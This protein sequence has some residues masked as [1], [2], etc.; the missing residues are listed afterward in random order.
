MPLNGKHKGRSKGLNARQ[1]K[2]CQLF[3]TF[4][5]ASQAFKD[6]GYSCKS[7]TAS[8]T[9]SSR[10]ISNDRITTRIS[11]LKAKTNAKL[12]L[13]RERAI[14][15]L[16]EMFLNESEKVNDRV[17]A[18]AAL[19]KTVGWLA[20]TR[21]EHD[22][23]DRVRAYLEDIRSRPLKPVMTGRYDNALKDAQVIDIQR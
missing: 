2:F 9:N 14:E 18:Y 3:V 4:G 19:A 8:R 16:G 5:V 15:V 6:A 17:T 1:E 10:L 7:E 23:G 12:S 11:E 22:L 20:P 21:V 13:T